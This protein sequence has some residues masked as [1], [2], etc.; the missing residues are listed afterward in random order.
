VKPDPTRIYVARP[1][2]GAYIS[3]ASQEAADLL[4]D[5]V[6]PGLKRYGDH[7]VVVEH[8]EWW[9]DVADDPETAALAQA[10]TGPASVMVPTVLG[11]QPDEGPPVPRG[12]GRPPWTKE[13]FYRKY[14]EARERAGP[15]V[16]DAELATGA[17]FMY[18]DGR[19]LGRLIA[20]FGLP[21][22]YRA[23]KRRL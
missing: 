6:R 2:Y 8:P 19:Q 7:P 3:P 14:R 9:V 16:S 23:N 12:R 5:T 4:D 18:S 1:P 13:G 22:E 20:K 21:P 10:L 17:P 11:D 15:D